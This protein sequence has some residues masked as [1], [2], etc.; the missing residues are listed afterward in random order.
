[1]KYDKQIPPRTKGAPLKK[2]YYEEE[3]ALV[4]LIKEKVTGINGFSKPLKT[5]E[6][7]IM[8]IA[9]D[10]AYS[11]CDFEDALKAGFTS[12]LDIIRL[13]G[14]PIL[15]RRLAIKVWKKI[16]DENV[17]FDDESKIPDRY[18]DDIEEAEELVLGLLEETAS[19]LIPTLADIDKQLAQDGITPG[20][21]G[22]NDEYLRYRETTAV[23]LAY[24]AANKLQEDGY[25]RTQ[26]ISDVVGEFI[27]GVTL[28]LDPD[29]PALSEVLVSDRVKWKIEALK[30]YTYE[31]HIE[32]TRLKSFESR[33]KEIVGTI[34]ERLVKSPTLLPSDW[35]V[36]YEAKKDDRAHTT[37]CISDFIAGMTDRYALAFFQR[38]T[39]GDPGTIF[40]DA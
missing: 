5:I 13:R 12:P 11:T 14:E 19:D 4:K 7:Q 23:S 37:R 30:R 9:D 38:Q 29:I 2:G 39:G 3:A 36:R 18:K 24:Q 17:T 16:K 10:I 28:K 31:S 8:D 34:F 22:T 33:G 15:L 6:C 25:A 40:R 32:T 35:R 27:Q 1:L 26:A 21:F 20:D